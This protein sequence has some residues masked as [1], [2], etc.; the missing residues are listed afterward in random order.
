VAV[1]GRNFAVHGVLVT[2]RRP[3]PLVASLTAIASQTRPFDRLIVVD[4]GPCA[5]NERAVHDLVPA[6]E[7]VAAPDNLGPAGGIAVGMRRVL[8]H[9][10]DDDWVMTLDDDDPL[11]EPGATAMLTDF[12]AESRAR[13]P[14]T[15]GVGRSGTRFNRRLGRI[16][17]VPDDELRGAVPVDCI[18]GNQHPLYAVRALRA[19]G[20]PRA[21]LFFGLEELE[22]GVRLRDAGYALYGHGPTWYDGRDREGRLGAR[23]EP[24]HSLADATWRRYY[25][26]RNLVWILREL[27]QPRSALRVTLVTGVAKPVANLAVDPRSALRHLGLNLAACRDAWT[28]RMGRTVDPST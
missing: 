15:G 19:V 21:E 13:D 23:L 8:A 1:G 12:A 28:N 14:A 7:Y 10:G 11:P 27:G 3:Q 2:Y 4:N 20:P 22:F 16:V 6:A 25:S 26:L 5:E 24:A 17:R 9:A 18:A